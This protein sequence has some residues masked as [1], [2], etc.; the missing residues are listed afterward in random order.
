MGKQDRRWLGGERQQQ[1]TAPPFISS[2]SSSSAA[3]ALIPVDQ[4]Q[5]GD[6][7]RLMDLFAVSED[8]GG[9]PPAMDYP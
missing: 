1:R 4:T 9:S 8:V 2:L 7:C 6:I 5:L 3:L